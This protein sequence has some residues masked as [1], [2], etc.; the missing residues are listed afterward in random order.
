M[1]T[2]ELVVPRSMPMTLSTIAHLYTTPYPVDAPE[3]LFRMGELLQV[4]GAPF[5]VAE[6]LERVLDGLKGG[7]ELL[8]VVPERHAEEAVG[9]ELLRHLE[10]G[11]LELLAVG[12]GR[13]TQKLEG[14][15]RLEAR[16]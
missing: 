2:Q 6:D 7:G 8:A 1:A 3:R 16:E 9:V 11:A 13:H 15:A 5:L 4:G 12:G 14:G 10:I